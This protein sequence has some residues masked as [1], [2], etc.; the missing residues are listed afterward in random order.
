MNPH[1]WKA[2]AAATVITPAEPM[3][4]AGWA[5]RREPATSTAMDLFAKALAFEDSQGECAVIVTADLIA[6]P[7][8]LAAAVAARVCGR[9]HIS[10]ERLLFNASHTHSGPEVRPDKIPFFEIPPEYAGRIAP[11]VSQ[12]EERI[13][14]VIELALERVQPATLNV[15]RLH[16]AFAANR[17]SPGGAVDHDVPVLVVRRSDGNPL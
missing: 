1:D 10:R 5:S 13:S 3:W 15:N 17:R 8:E 16:A 7:R 2:G 4:L 6:I 9:R 11:Y 12:L 14:A